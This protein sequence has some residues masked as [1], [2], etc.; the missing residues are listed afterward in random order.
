MMLVAS[1]PR[2][3]LPRFDHDQG[4]RQSF[5]DI[6]FVFVAMLWLGVLFGVSFL[7]TP[8]KFQAPSLDLPVALDVGRVTFALLSKT[9]WVFCAILFVTTLFTLRSRRVRLGVVVLLALL[10]LVQALWLLP[11]LDAR[12]SQIIAGMTVSGTSHHILYIGA[13]AL[14]FLLLL[15]LSIEALWTLAGSRKIQRCG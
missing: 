13:E 8:V 10:L 2:P 7:A 4:A 12:V 3:I 6:P 14:K 5:G 1:D 15:G 11:V 9:E